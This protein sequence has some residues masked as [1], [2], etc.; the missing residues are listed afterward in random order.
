[1]E[2]KCHEQIKAAEKE[3]YD[4]KGARAEIEGRIH[5]QRPSQAAN[6]NDEKVFDKILEKNIYQKAR[7]KMKNGKAK[8]EGDEEKIQQ[9][10]YLQPILSKL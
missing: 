7:D 4:E 1:M 10:D 3:T 5:Q 9:K 8:D 6:K 2:R